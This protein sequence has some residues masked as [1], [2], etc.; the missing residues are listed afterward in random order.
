MRLDPFD[1]AA[2]SNWSNGKLKEVLDL[3]RI[4]IKAGEDP[5]LPYMPIDSIP[6]KSF[7]LEELR[8]NEEAKSSLIKFDKDDIIIGAMRVYFHRVILAPCSGITRTTCFVLSPKE[9]EYLSF[10]LLLCNQDSSIAFAEKTS[11]GST[12]PYAVWEGGLSEMEI[13]I[14]SYDIAKR[15]NDIAL[16]ILRRIQISYFEKKYLCEL[17]DSLLPKLIS[18]D[19]DVSEINI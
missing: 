6:M 2:P 14:P 10:L 18:G 5:S 11:K 8:P 16:P 7:A 1:G 4:S 9:S 17:R 19:I 3:K 13:L 12:M 15:F